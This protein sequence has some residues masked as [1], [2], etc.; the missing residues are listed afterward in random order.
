MVAILVEL[1]PVLCPFPIVILKTPIASVLVL[2]SSTK[3]LV[4]FTV[5]WMILDST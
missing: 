1:P 2:C 4:P 5:V 3:T